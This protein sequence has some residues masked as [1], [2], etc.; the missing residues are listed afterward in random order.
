MLVA[1]T[2]AG[3]HEVNRPLDYFG[4]AHL[5]YYLDRATDIVHADV[6]TCAHDQPV[7]GDR[8]RTIRDLQKDEIREI[9]LAEAIHTAVSNNKLIR[10][11]GS[12]SSPFNT[13]LNNPD[14]NPSAYDPGI[15]GTGF[16][17][18]QRGVEAALADFDMQFTTTATWGR[19]ERIQNTPLFG[20]GF[21]DTRIDETAQVTM[22]AEKVIATGGRFVLSH[23]WDY[24]LN[25]LPS[26][27]FP[28]S[29]NGVTQLEFRQPIWQGAGVEFTRIAGPI[30]RNLQ[31]VSGVNQGVAIARI[32]NDI[33]IADFEANVRNML[34]DVEDVYWDLYLAYRI[35]HSEVQARDSALQTWREV[36]ARFDQGLEN[37]SAAE[38][39]QARD[40]YFEA[41]VR[42]ENSLADIYAY[43][44]RLRRM[45]GLPV[46]DGMILRP[47][48]D[49]TTA[50][51]R[52]DWHLAIAEGL[53]RR[54][55]LRRQ[56]WNIK[57]LELQLQAAHSL[58]KP[59]VDLVS[60]YR[61]NG[62]GDELWT[63]DDDDGI[64]AQGYKSGMGSMFN[65]QETGW[66]LG[67][68]AS[69]PLG[70]RTGHSAVRH[71]ELRLTKARAAL[72][73]M[74]LEVAHELSNA[75][76]TLDRSYRT[77]QINR[78][79]FEAAKNRV[80]AFEAQFLAG[81]TTVDLLLRAQT[82]L[83]AA[84]TAYFQSLVAYNK[85]I[86]EIHYRKGT[87]LELNNVMLQEG[88]W[89]P[90]A[91]DLAIRRAWARS[92]AFDSKSHHAEPTEFAMPH[93]P[94]TEFGGWSEGSGGS[95]PMP[96]DPHQGIIPPE[97]KSEIRRDTP[98]PEKTPTPKPDPLNG[99]P[100]PMPLEGPTA[101]AG[102]RYI[103]Q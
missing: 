71:Y 12:F 63:Y 38:E 49:P 8:P 31:G 94:G 69:M 59:R 34:K 22:G 68:Q 101:G 5:E 24:S 42:A 97:P 1:G 77:A 33:S 39:A 54:V 29:Y 44:T 26:Q 65:G 79:R 14:G 40:N 93:P 45:L 103:E 30:G 96:L 86:A 35:Y 70:F 25:N 90:E 6:Q 72:G 78:N 11:A 16:L 83:A 13:L 18:G 9:S 102:R 67:V 91:Y 48:E 57:S 19:D 84:E 87:L 17:F 80:E 73:Q 2:L 36:K 66:N 7:I 61:V 81:R 52:P 46:N 62:F 95:T 41:K 21:G 4:D 100:Q 53:T 15:Q 37:A 55:E 23:N 58:T 82:S 92:F 64:T 98:S 43:E 20:L 56:K 47:A 74:E 50:E 89:E 32:N 85:A 28:S 10:S 75:F 3:C 51:Y 27:L 60:N 99:A 76:Q 88:D